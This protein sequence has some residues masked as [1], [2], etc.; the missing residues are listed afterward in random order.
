[1]KINKKSIILLYKTK[2]ITIEGLREAV[3][4]EWITED[5]FT[6]IINENN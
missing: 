5:D 1:M 6:E 4:R 2:K 3:K